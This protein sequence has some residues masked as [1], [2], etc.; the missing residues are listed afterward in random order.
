MLCSVWV[1]VMDCAGM[2]AKGSKKKKKQPQWPFVC[3]CPLLVLDLL[4]GWGCK[5]LLGSWCFCRAAKVSR[6]NFY[7]GLL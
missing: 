2:L 1:T 7:Y 4:L 5:M 6:W 3:Y